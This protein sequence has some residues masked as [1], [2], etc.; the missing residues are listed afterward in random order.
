[1]LFVRGECWF[2]RGRI[3]S[4][5]IANDAFAVQEYNPGVDFFAK[6]GIKSLLERN[7]SDP[8]KSNRA[9]DA[10]KD[11]LCS[12]QECLPRLHLDSLLSSDRVKAVVEHFF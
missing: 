10:L 5:G 1:M 7:K 11:D 6:R 4:L 8:S 9:A 3:R 2:F 12:S